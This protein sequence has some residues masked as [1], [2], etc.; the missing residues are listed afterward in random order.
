MVFTTARETLLRQRLGMCL[1]LLLMI[2]VVVV[3]VLLNFEIQVPQ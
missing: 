1:G 2:F 3:I